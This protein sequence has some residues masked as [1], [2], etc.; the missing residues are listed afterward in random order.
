MRSFKS[1]MIPIIIILIL[2]ISS[3]VLFKRIINK[4]FNTSEDI[5]INVQ[6]G[7]SF[8]SII[9]S[10]SKENQIKGVQIIKLYVKLSGK[11][12][13]V[14]QGEYVLRN[15]LSVN[16][17]INTLTSDS[18]LDVVKFTV[19]EGY[20]IDDIAEKLEKEGICSKD[21][22]IRAVKEYEPPSFVKINSEKIYN[23]E[24]YLFPDTYLIKVGETPR[25]IISK[26]VFRFKEVLQEAL[27]ETNMTVKDEDIET[28]VNI[29][30]MIEKEARIDSERPMISSVI[31]N[32]LNINMMLQID[33]TVI[34][35]LGEHVN[36][37]LESHLEINSPYNTYKNYGLPIG[38]I[39]NPGLASIKAALKPEKTD[40][41]FYVLQDDKTHYFTNND[42]DFMNK[43][44]ELGY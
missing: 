39:S 32:R 8:Y 20:T 15:D 1:K 34:Y 28:V 3:F 43:L 5:V 14:K 24:G 37:V 38:P 4:P 44:K 12:I 23:L 29:A 7:D 31:I 17:L 19:P 41:L 36:T 42:D 40:Y 30:S 27:K 13:D 2:T 16:E 11:N 33:A 25:E 9:D 18:T 22:F 35:A 10:L 26:M 6:E 21:D